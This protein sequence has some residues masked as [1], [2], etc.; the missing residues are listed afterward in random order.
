MQEMETEIR[1]LRMENVFLK[2]V[3]MTVREL[4]VTAA[5]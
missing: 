3:P 2:K 4:A 5:V 1:R